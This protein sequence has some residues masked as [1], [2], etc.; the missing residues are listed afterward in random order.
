M[1]RKPTGGPR[2][3]R[4]GTARRATDKL[5]ND[6]PGFRV[7]QRFG[8]WDAIFRNRIHGA[9]DL[10]NF[11]CRDRV[12]AMMAGKAE[13]LLDPN[14]ALG[15]A[16]SHPNGYRTEYW[17]LATRKVANGSQVKEGQL[18]G[19]VGSTGLDIG[20]CHLHVRV[21]DPA[22]KPVDPWPLIKTGN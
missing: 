9:M 17:H 16:V 6:H 2:L 4:F 12:V 3:V 1:F 7:T 18:L 11:F 13:H 5:A 20:G 10:G 15:V 21:I 8:D 22:G 19:L 14:G